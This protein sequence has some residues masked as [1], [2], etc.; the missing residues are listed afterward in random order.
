MALAVTVVPRL[1]PGNIMYDESAGWVEARSA[2]WLAALK[3]LASAFAICACNGS[4]L[5]CSSSVASYCASAPQPICNWSVY[6]EPTSFNCQFT[7]LST[8]CGSYDIA[9]QRGVDT[10][11]ESY[12]ERTNGT[13]VAAVSVSAN[14]GSGRFCIAGPSSGFSEPTCPLSGFAASCPDGGS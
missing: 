1:A 6:T 4:Q 13:L 2:R 7:V 9:Y 3:V 8:S 5:P 10:A 11:V 14:V 12:Y